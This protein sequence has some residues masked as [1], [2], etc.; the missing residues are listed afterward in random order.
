[1]ASVDCKEGI[2]RG[3]SLHGLVVY[4][5][6]YLHWISI[7]VNIIV[8]QSENFRYALDTLRIKT[9]SCWQPVT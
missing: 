1:M 2:M 7:F 3:S 6:D 5:C 9:R 4:Q 8:N